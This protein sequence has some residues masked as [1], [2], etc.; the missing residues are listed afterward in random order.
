MMTEWD[1]QRLNQDGLRQVLTEAEQTPD[2]DLQKLSHLGKQLE[3]YVSQMTADENARYR[4][5]LQR[6]QNLQHNHT[7]N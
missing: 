6:F 2:W 3:K 1:V 4:G 7:G 5:I